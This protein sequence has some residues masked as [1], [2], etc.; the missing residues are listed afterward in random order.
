MRT[1]I[2][3]PALK[4]EESFYNIYVT[5]IENAKIATIQRKAK[6]VWVEEDFL[7]M[8]LSSTHIAAINLKIIISYDIHG[9]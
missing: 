4:N 2:S 3:L 9:M 5:Y 8:E 1:A 6:N 7:K